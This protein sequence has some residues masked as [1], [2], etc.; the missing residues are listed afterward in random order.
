M[1]YGY[2]IEFESE[3]CEQC[4]RSPI[5]FN[6]KEQDIITKLLAK[7]EDKGVIVKSE[8]E[9]GEILSHVFIRPKADG[10]YRL[11]LNLSRLN[12]HVDKI[13]FKMETLRS[14]LQMIRKSCWFAKCDLKDAFYSVAI[15]TQYRKYLKFEWEGELY[16]FTCLPNGLSTASRIFTKVLKPVFAALRKIGHSNVAY[17][18]DSLLLS[19]SYEQCV[20]NIKDTMK[21]IDSVGLTT[22]PEKSIIEPTQCIEFVGFL[23]NSVEMTVQLAPRKVTKL[24]E[25]AIKTL[26]AKS[27]TI[28]E[29]AK[30]IGTM[31][32][33][34][35]GVKYAA[36]YYKTLELDKDKALKVNKGN[37]EGDVSLSVQSK[38]CIHWWINNIESAYKPISMGPMNR[39]IETD[40]SL[41]GYGGHDVTNDTEFSGKWSEEDK[42]FHI[43]YLELK[44]AFLAIKFF[45]KN[46]S[47]EHVHLF[48]DNTVALK[49]ISKMGG[50]KPML[51]ALAKELWE[52]C[53]SK[54]LWIS[55]FHIP[56]RF[57]IRA[58][59]LS[60][61]KRKC[62][63]DMEWALQQDIYD[64]IVAKM[65]QSCDIDLFASQHN[66]K[67]STFISYVPNKGAIA[68]NAFSVI[69][70]Y[71][72]HYAF[73]PF[74]L[75]GRVIQKMCEDQAE[76]ILIAPLFPSQPW[77]PPVMKQICGT[78]FVL[79]KTDRILY[80]PGTQKQ[81]NLTTMR[82]AAFHL[83][84]NALSVQ[85]YQK[86]LPTSLCNRGGLQQ[87]SNMG[88]ISKD[89]C[90]FVVN[91]RLIKLTHL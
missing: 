39:R 60:R 84:G 74:S 65:G 36:A 81:H 58:D 77:F 62:S 9:T 48:I 56:G 29:F 64:K 52:W 85:A 47:N 37:F 78:C 20:M 49:Y 34:E 26:K 5:N 45:C 83:S 24:K 16:E 67:V 15:A 55:A 25:L 14:A 7:F 50:R 42:K 13:T 72:L 18:D 51:N 46:V 76:V 6:L 28:R 80:Q 73:P 68:V 22:H 88:L 66:N 91:N 69:W 1:K 63:V 32:A 12:E 30:L 54:H 35:P 61:A 8:H 2:E 38:Q 4:N 31:V 79:P 86:T 3:P 90:N 59:E 70:N 17:I 23:L 33:A 11:I 21:L 75:I 57:N 41:E 53:E 82:L 43:N 44:A 87:G 19:D 40:S 10:T 89:G 27:V 71:T